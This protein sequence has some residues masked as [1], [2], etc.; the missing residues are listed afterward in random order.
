MVLFFYHL[1][2]SPN[3]FNGPLNTR[4]HSPHQLA[5]PFHTILEFR[6]DIYNLQSRMRLFIQ[7]NG[8]FSSSTALD[9]GTENFA[10]M[11]TCFNIYAQ[12]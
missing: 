3:Q 10:V 11:R 2:N 9:R 6:I 12:E 4:I 8:F 7:C 1:F 5:Q